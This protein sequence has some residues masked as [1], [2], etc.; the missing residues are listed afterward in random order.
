MVI[1]VLCLIAA[2]TAVVGPSI[3]NRL[4]R[5]DADSP[6]SGSYVKELLNDYRLTWGVSSTEFGEFEKT[7]FQ[8]RNAEWSI[9]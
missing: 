2:L 5:T 6:S 9:Y 8:R 4:E 7:A 1:A 3:W